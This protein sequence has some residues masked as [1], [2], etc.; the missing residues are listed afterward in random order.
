MLL[1]SR[2]GSNGA[3]TFACMSIATNE[4]HPASLLDGEELRRTGAPQRRI[5]PDEEQLITLTEGTRDLPKVKGKK[6]PVCILCGDCDAAPIPSTPGA[7]G[8]AVDTLIDARLVPVPC[9]A[10]RPVPR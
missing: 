6:V 5:G 3:C 1:R 2:R 8:S 4:T 10:R 7:L 9:H